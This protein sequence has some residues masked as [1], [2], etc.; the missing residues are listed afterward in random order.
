MGKIFTEF[1]KKVDFTGS[2]IY[3]LLYFFNQLR[4]KMLLE[5]KNI[6]NTI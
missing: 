3:F 5:K 4:K 1:M 6:I 2:K